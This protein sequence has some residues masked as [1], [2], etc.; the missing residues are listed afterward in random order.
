VAVRP[1]GQWDETLGR[2]LG[3]F[4]PFSYWHAMRVRREV[5]R[6]S[7]ASNAAGLRLSDGKLRRMCPSLYLTTGLTG[8]TRCLFG[9]GLGRRAFIRDMLIHGDGRAAVVVASDPLRIACYCDDSDAVCVLGF[10]ERDVGRTT[11]RDGDRLLTVLNSAIDPDAPVAGDL[12]QGDRADPNYINFWP[13]VAELICDDD[14]EIERC[15]AAIS[16]DEYR[17]CR[18]LAEEHERRLPGAVRDGRA[19]QSLYPAC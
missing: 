10:R 11:F 14:A 12:V 3:S 4:G 9:D 8:L 2:G 17:R 18:L 5:N 16:S 7:S 1:R 15:K 13:L 6:G 19:D